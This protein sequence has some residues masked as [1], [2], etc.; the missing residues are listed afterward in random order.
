MLTFLALLQIFTVAAAAL[1]PGE[2][3]RLWMPM[4]PLLMAPIGLELTTWPARYRMVAY[5]CLWLIMVLIC[6]N[7]AFIHMGP[8]LDGPR[9]L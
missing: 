9:T 5:A 6:Q 2:A 1:L 7:M 3:P 4:L 8:A